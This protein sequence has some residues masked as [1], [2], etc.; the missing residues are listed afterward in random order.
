MER[1]AY[2]KRGLKFPV[3]L[4][5]KEGRLVLQKPCLWTITLLRILDG[6]PQCL[7]GRA[8]EEKESIPVRNQNQ[9]YHS[10]SQINKEGSIL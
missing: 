10:N 4:W 7:A 3:L 8:G 6:W 5:M 1:K 2:R 9:G